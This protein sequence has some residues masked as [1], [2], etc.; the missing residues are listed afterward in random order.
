VQKYLATAAFLAA[1]T[2]VQDFLPPPGTV[3]TQTLDLRQILT[4][5]TTL[6][7]CRPQDRPRPQRITTQ[8]GRFTASRRSKCGSGE[9]KAGVEPRSRFEASEAGTESGSGDLGKGQ[10]PL[11]G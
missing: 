2:K 6:V 11:C 1:L 9:R 8:R 10:A 4:L 7:S 5:A 3:N